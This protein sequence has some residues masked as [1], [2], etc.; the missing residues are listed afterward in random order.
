MAGMP[1]EESHRGKPVI[2]DTC[3]QHSVAQWEAQ[4]CDRKNLPPF[5]VIYQ[6]G[7]D[8]ISPSRYTTAMQAVP[9]PSTAPNRGEAPSFLHPS[10]AT[11]AKMP[12][13]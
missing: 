2:D 6:N 7:L 3:P 5:T 9:M 4:T 11:G 12:V 8:F 13:V 10:Y 1:C